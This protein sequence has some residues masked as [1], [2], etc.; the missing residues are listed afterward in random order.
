MG[1]NEMLRPQQK[2]RK[3]TFEPFTEPD[4]NPNNLFV[5]GYGGNFAQNM[6]LD[7]KGIE[8]VLKI[9]HL[10]GRVFLFAMPKSRDRSLNGVNE[11][12]SADATETVLFDENQ[13]DLEDEKNPLFRTVPVPE[14]WKIEINDE[15]M[16]EKL[17]EERL[18]GKKLQ[19]KFVQGFN[20]IFT[21][22]VFEC[23]RRE[24]LTGVKDEFFG[25]KRKSSLFCIGYQS[26]VTAAFAINSSDPL[27]VSIIG[28]SLYL[29]TNLGGNILTSR[30]KRSFYE[31]RQIDH[32]WEYLMPPLEIDKV[33]RAFAFL[34]FPG[35]KLVREKS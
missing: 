24:K 15:M 12:G 33:A 27:R 10:N 31:A 29:L 23:I 25:E 30:N 3:N 26:V 20:G 8:A 16:L 21:A 14:G 22:A 5:N 18:T 9:A 7:R 6:E 32:L 13:E 4:D 1:L 19:A 28:G 34:S 35:K 17:Q 11:D 2:E